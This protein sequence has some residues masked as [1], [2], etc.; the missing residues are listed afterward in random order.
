MIRQ[1]VLLM[2]ISVTWSLGQ[3]GELLLHFDNCD[4]SLEGNGIS[5]TLSGVVDCECGIYGQALT[6]N[7]IN[8]RVSFDS[9][10]TSYFQNDF[11]LSFYFMPNDVLRGAIDI[12][13]VADDCAIDSTLSI[14]YFP[15]ANTVQVQMAKDFDAFVE[16]EGQ[17]NQD[18]CWHQVVFQRNDRNYNLFIDGKFVD[19]AFINGSI[20]LDPSA[21]MKLSGSPCQGFGDINFAGYIDEFRIVDRVE[22]VEQI[23]NNYTIT[24]QIITPDTTVFT[25][26]QVQIRQFPSCAQNIAWNPIANVITFQDFE[27]IIAPAQS[28]TYRV[29]YDYGICQGTDT[30][31][32]SVLDAE[33]V[34]CDNLLVPNAFTP[35]NDGLNDIFE[36][37][38]SFIIEELGYFDIYDRWG[39]KVFSTTDKNQGWDGTFRGKAVNPNIYLYKINYTCKNTQ[40]SKAGSFSI[41]R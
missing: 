16:L 29:I 1:V 11:T 7:G 33:L 41:L 4:G 12:L 10:Y 39:E 6:F 26:G 9:S 19:E 40:F 17:L 18:K 24:D 23:I 28:T 25:G 3:S 8:T 37:S 21:T 27:P 32:V 15:E 14:K 13:S 31:S 2:L 5:P 30:I 34:D 20:E 35:N 22:T 38:N 36:V